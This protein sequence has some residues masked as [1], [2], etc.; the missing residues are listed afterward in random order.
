MKK[1]LLPTDFSCNSR[2][3][4]AYALNFYKEDFCEFTLLNVFH[5]DGYLDHTP[6]IPIP[7]NELRLE[8]QIREKKLNMLVQEIKR[9][10][11]NPKHHYKILFKNLPL[12]SLLNEEVKESSFELILIGT[13]GITNDKDMAYGANTIKIIEN[14]KDCPVFAIPSHVKF[15]E[16]REIVLA[17]GFK[18]VPRPKEYIFIKE[19][20]KKTH[21][22]LRILYI[23]EN[24]DLSPNQ[25]KNKKK[26]IQI[27]GEVP[28]KFHS[29]SYVSVPIGIYC[30][31]ESRNSDIITFVNQKHGFFKNVLFNPIYKNIGKHS[32]IPV[33]I[34]Q[35]SVEKKLNTSGT[36]R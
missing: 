32:K 17:T 2:S 14:I 10:Y 33:L 30:F 3:A 29:L 20:I 11:P 26:L 21:A 9:R 24:G 22:I 27:L 31:T 15:S 1:I 34:V 25:V 19:L 28:H 8:K 13:Q 5:I 23:E 35:T 16:C 12:I 6:V 7:E 18:T 4:I 36:S